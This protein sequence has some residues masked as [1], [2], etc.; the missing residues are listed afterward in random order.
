MLTQIVGSAVYIPFW[1][2]DFLD[3]ELGSQGTIARYYPEKR[4]ALDIGDAKRSINRKKQRILEQ[5]GFKYL[6]LP[7]A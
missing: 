2:P 1:L 3:A 5:Y 4:I 7:E 6:I